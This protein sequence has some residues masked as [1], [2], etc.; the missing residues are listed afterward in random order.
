MIKKSNNYDQKT[1]LTIGIP[2]YRRPTYL[3]KLLENISK[4]N[5][6]N[7]EIIISENDPECIKSEKV[8]LSFNNLNIKYY[9]QKENVGITKFFVLLEVFR[10]LPEC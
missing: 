7:L 3:K 6:K 2:T 1:L 10:I 4:Y 5:Y 9:R 8:A